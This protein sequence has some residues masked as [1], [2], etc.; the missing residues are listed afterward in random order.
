MHHLVQKKLISDTQAANTEKVTLAIHLLTLKRV[1]LGHIVYDFDGS[2][3]S[4]SFKR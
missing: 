1:Q 3:V 4:F 2:Y